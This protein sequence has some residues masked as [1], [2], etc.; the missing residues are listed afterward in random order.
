MEK[1]KCAD[2][3]SISVLKLVR[4]GLLVSSHQPASI[5]LQTENHVNFSSICVLKLV[6]RNVLIIRH[7]PLYSI[8]S[9]VNSSPNGMAVGE[10]GGKRRRFFGLGRR[11][12]GSISRTISQGV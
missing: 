11:G 7:Q 1:G 5:Y 12:R 3:T 6:R 10:E 2:D 8:K 4:R 9:H